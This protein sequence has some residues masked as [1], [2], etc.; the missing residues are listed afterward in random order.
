MKSEAGCRIS[1]IVSSNPT[2]TRDVCLID[3]PHKL[4]YESSMT[5]YINIRVY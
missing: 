2:V 4:A 3:T 1:V 5:K